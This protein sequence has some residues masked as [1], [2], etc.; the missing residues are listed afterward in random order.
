MDL[1]RKLGFGLMVLGGVLVIVWAIEPIGFIWPWV[2]GLPWP[3]R[4]GVGA[5]AIGI[6][7]LF[8]SLIQER[9]RDREKD[10]SLLDDF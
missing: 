5:A 10:K 4:I 6:A 7:V 1:M 8:G 3:L 9:I 2:R